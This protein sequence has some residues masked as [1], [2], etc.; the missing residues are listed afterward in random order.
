[1]NGDGSDPLQ[2]TNETEDTFHPRWSPDGTKI[3]YLVGESTNADILVVDADGKNRQV[4]K[5]G[6]VQ[7]FE[8]RLGLAWLDEDTLIYINPAS[9]SEYLEK[10][11]I[12]GS[13]QA[14]IIQPDENVFSC[15]Y[16][17]SAGKI[18]Y[19]GENCATPQ[20]PRGMFSVAPDGSGRKNFLSTGAYFYSARWNPAGTKIVMSQGDHPS[21][22]YVALVDP[23]GTNNTLAGQ[24]YQGTAK[25]VDW[26]Y[27]GS[28][29]IAA[30]PTPGDSDGQNEIWLMNV[31][32][33]NLTNLTNNDAS[34]I[35][36]DWFD[37][38]GDNP[39][40]GPMDLIPMIFILLGEN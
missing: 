18:I 11:D 1:M 8:M 17:S 31:N 21:N 5:S 33:S 14:V 29:I 15:D 3:A 9:C 40:T 13:N 26:A 34:D 23:D 10:I 39:K 24:Y 25:G 37:G 19:S 6:G 28:K 2:I 12:D 35:M 36:P 32:G 38:S 16:N 4:V 20:I 7:S 27:D 30:G 22:V